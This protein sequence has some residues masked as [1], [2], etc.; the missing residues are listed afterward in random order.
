MTN[1]SL[2]KLETL[3]GRYVPSDTPIT[4]PGTPVQYGDPTTGDEYGETSPHIKIDFKNV[5]TG[6]SYTLSLRV[7][8]TDGTLSDWINIEVGSTATA[9]DIAGAVAGE[10]NGLKI[11]NKS[12]ITATLDGTKVKIVGKEGK[13]LTKIW[14]H[15]NLTDWS[16]PTLVSRNTDVDY[17]FE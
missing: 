8:F 17:S 1:R 10:L 13:Q 9:T 12:V 6:S 11:D 3:D 5:S 4:P 2:L 16:K 15:S 7:N 14:V